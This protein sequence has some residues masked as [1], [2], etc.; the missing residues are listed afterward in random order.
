MSTITETVPALPAADT[1]PGSESATT[2]RLYR[3]IWRWHFYAGL[4]VVPFMLMLA[5]T[6]IIYLYKPQLDDLMYPTRVAPAATTQPPSVLIAAVLAQYPGATLTAFQTTE[7]ADRS[8]IVKIS[9]ASGESRSVFVNPTTTEVLGERNDDWNLQEVAV[10]LHGSLLLGDSGDYLV[11]L[12]AC[13]GLILTISGLYLWWPRKGSKIW[14]VLLPRLTTKNRR[15][16]WRDLHAVPGFWASLVVIFLIVSGLPWAT[17]WGTNFA[18]VWAQYPAELWDNVPL[19]DTTAASLNTGSE[20]I[21]PWAAEDTP[22]PQSD[23]HADHM[24][25]SASVGAETSALGGIAPGVPI[26]VDSV[27]AFGQAAGVPAG[28]SVTPPDGAEGVYTITIFADQPTLSRTIHI[29]QYSGRALADIGWAQYGLV[30]KLVET[31]IALHEGR[32]FGFWNQLLML[33]AALTVVL[34][35]ITGP[36]MWWQRRPKGRLGAPAMPQLRLMRGLLA[37]IIVLGALFPLAGLSFALVVA[38]DWLVLRRVPVLRRM[39][40]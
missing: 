3:L 8:A 31:G 16:F 24:A 32:F 9:T 17:F 21:V 11:E 10:Q 28:F 14:G 38:L 23:L 15:L 33:F 22:L 34:L 35:A 39:L 19:S 12:A 4:F 36:V 5:V 6:G 1:A 27:V 20:K 18:R 25:G 2:S 37:I 13:W 29:D 40:V 30:P 7:A 26:D